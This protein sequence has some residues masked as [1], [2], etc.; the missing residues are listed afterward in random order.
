M[1]QRRVRL[2]TGQLHGRNGRGG[3]GEN[4]ATPPLD[5]QTIDAASPTTVD[6]FPNGTGADTKTPVVLV[7]NE[8]IAPSNLSTEPPT[9]ISNC[10][11]LRPPTAS[12]CR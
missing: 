10:F 3:V 11:L 4:P 5:G 7:F 8:S 12:P 1:R 2:R 9:T 6:I